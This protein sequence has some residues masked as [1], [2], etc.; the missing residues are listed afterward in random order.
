MRLATQGIASAMAFAAT[1]EEALPATLAISD[2]VGGDAARA[3]L[4]LV[5]FG[6]RLGFMR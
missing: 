1:E 2:D 3:C 5:T 6:E 4:A